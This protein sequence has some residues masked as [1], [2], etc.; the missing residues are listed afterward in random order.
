MPFNREP[1]A[2]VSTSLPQGQAAEL[3]SA[4]A[5]DQPVVSV[6]DPASLAGAG[7]MDG[8]VAALRGSALPSSSGSAGSPA[9]DGVVPEVPVLKKQRV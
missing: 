1:A 9:P 2:Y 7:G 8:K 5:F 4:P 6:R 3:A